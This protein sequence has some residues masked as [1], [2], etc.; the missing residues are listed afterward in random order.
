MSN[1]RDLLT[2]YK[3]LCYKQK[4]L[5]RC[6]ILHTFLTDCKT[7]WGSIFIFLRKRVC[8]YV[9]LLRISLTI[10][11]KPVRLH[12]FLEI[13]NYFSYCL[14]FS[15]CVCGGYYLVSS[16]LSVFT[17][18]GTLFLSYSFS[19]RRIY[20]SGVLTAGSDRLHHM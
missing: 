8:T 4:I 20:I 13:Y 3:Y 19:W 15:W 11:V 1:Y 18:I 12:S 5:S 14:I 6:F 16:F 10:M 2:Y 17:T 7:G 9:Y